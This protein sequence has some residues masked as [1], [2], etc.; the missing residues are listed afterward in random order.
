M[1]SPF[2]TL[3][4][5]ARRQ[6]AAERCELCSLVLA[7]E[8]QHLIDPVNRKLVCSCDACAILFSGQQNGRFR[9]VPRRIEYLEDF[10]LS[11]LQWE[12]L[13]LPINL[14]FFFHSTPAGRVI[15]VY[16]SPGGATESQ[17]PPEAWQHLQEDN[18][19]LRELDPDVEALLVYR[20][21]AAREHYRVPIDECYKLVGLVR[22]TWKG[23][24][25]GVQVWEVLARFFDG[26][27][28][29]SQPRRKAADA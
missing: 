14:A 26:L 7:S 9:R 19:V 1:P 5:L 25:G 3:R 23:L 8:H 12:E 18:P 24:S 15:A 21:G 10:R 16:P 29:K 4:N 20:V 17:P 27:R 28:E 13:G 6:P 11:D 2:S 22:T